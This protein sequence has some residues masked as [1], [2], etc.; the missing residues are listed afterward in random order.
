MPEASNGVQWVNDNFGKLP[1]LKLV[2]SFTKMDR[3]P[4]AQLAT[5]PQV[6]EIDAGARAVR[7]R[8]VMREFDLLK[9]RIDVS[10]KIFK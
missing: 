2:A 10:S 8:H 3:A 6:M 7:Y 1:Y 9:T 4:L 5:G